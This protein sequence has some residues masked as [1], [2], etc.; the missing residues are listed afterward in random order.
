M[1]F[2]SLQCSPFFTSYTLGPHTLVAFIGEATMKFNLYLYQQWSQRAQT[3]SI[4]NQLFSTSVQDMQPIHLKDKTNTYLITFYIQHL[5]IYIF[6]IN[7]SAG[8]VHAVQ[9]KGIFVFMH[10]FH[11]NYAMVLSC[12]QFTQHRSNI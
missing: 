8:K 3:V 12:H 5:F 10:D 9:G 6:F 1:L 7:L 11:K 4:F 2:R